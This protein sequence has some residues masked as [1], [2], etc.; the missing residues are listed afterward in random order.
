VEEAHGLLRAGLPS[1]TTAVAEKQQDKARP[2][3]NTAR[4]AGG[5]SGRARMHAGASPGHVAS[6]SSVGDWD[7]IPM[8]RDETP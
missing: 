6:N 5:Q 8:R 7:S 2:T 3:S 4:R 1:P